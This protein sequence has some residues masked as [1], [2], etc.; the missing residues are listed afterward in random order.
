MSSDAKTSGSATK[1]T[2]EQISIKSI[3]RV[4]VTGGA[5]G[6]VFIWI[7]EAFVWVWAQHL[8][9]L[10]GIPRNATGL[11]FGTEVQNS[12]GFMSYIVG[13]G[14]HFVF[15][16]FWGVVFAV[17]WPYFR[18]RG[19]EATLVA[20]VFA[21]IVWIAMRVPIILAGNTHP[22]YYDPAV[23]I[24]GFM[25]HFFFAIPMA[26]YVKPQMARP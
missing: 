7:Y 13:T 10:A 25:S 12:L 1:G 17:I 24:G 2:S 14:I 15:A 22:D 23:I 8:M 9:P 5:I 11:V 16:F 18:R 20:V 26:L 19:Y 6:G 21:P 3:I 4:G